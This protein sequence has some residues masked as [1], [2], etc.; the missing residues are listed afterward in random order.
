MLDLGAEKRALNHVKRSDDAL[1]YVK[2]QRNNTDIVEGKMFVLE[3]TVMAV[4]CHK[5]TNA[6]PRF[7]VESINA[8]DVQV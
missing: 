7:T 1:L 3:L 8:D 4:V 5:A 6:Q 2:D